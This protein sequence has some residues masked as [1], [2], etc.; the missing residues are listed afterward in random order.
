M[1]VPRLILA[2]VEAGPAVD[3]A[4]GA[5]LAGFG[6]QRAVRPVM[7]GL[8]LALWRLLYEGAGKAPRLLDPALHNASV[9]A[10]LFDQWTHAMDLA[11]MVA[12][13]PVL[14]RW[15]GV[16]GSR[17]VDYATRL[18]AP[19]ILVVDARDKGATAAAAVVGVRTLAREA[20]IGGVIVVGADESAGGRE[21]L[22]TLRRDAGLPLLGRIPPQLSEQFVRQCTIQ[23]SAVRTIGPKPPRDAAQRLTQE[24]AGYLQLEELDAV[25]SRRGYLPAV[26]RRV[27]ARETALEPL[28]LAVGWGPPLQPLA[29]ENVDVIQSCGVELKPLNIA[30]DRMLPAGVNGLLLCGQL[31]EDEIGAFAANS[32]LLGQLAQAVDEGLPTMAFGGGALLLLRRLADSHGRSYD[33]AGVVP[34]EAELIEWYER[35]RYVRVA[36][37]RDNPYD[38]GEN[39]LYELFDLEYLMLEQESFA[40]RVHTAGNG[41]QAEGFALHRCLATTLYPSFALSPGVADRFVQAMRLAGTWE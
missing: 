38:E 13:R 36:A 29:L 15:E 14:D 28:A 21:L 40:Y 27:F 1:S 33:L 17:A 12:A 2:G 26:Q 31:D 24:A 4:A 23:T 37:T 8:D 30:R 18:D 22:E 34:A 7:I 35:P 3:L 32:D 9:S 11:V 10:E 39:V 41:G 19:L 25:A 6:R 20:E 5:V 16:E